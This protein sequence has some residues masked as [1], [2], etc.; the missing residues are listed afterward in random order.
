MKKN[1]LSIAILAFIFT[2]CLT[3]NNTS[4]GS[5]SD[6]KSATGLKVQGK[7][8][9]VVDWE[10]YSIGAEAVP[11]WLESA[12]LGN[13][14]AYITTFNKSDSDIYRYSTAT[15][16][17]L[18]SAQMRADMNYSRKIAKE[19]QQSINV[20]S[21]EQARAG[22]LSDTT[23]Q[24]IEEVT[25]TQSSVEIT[26]HQKATEFWQQV[27]VSDP[28]TGEKTSEY[29]VYQIYQIPAQTWA[30]TTAKYIKTVIGGVP[31]ELSPEQDFVKNLVSEMMY[32]ARFSTVMSQKEKEQQIEINKQ[33]ADIQASL[34]PAEQKAAADQALVQIMQSGQ[35]ERT[36]IITDAKVQQTQAMADATKIAYASGNPIYQSAATI[37][38]ADKDW[39]DAE[40]LAASILFN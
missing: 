33:M 10:G 40:A 2:G 23:R 16:Q 34:A 35:T 29:I 18:R 22:N 25:K 7:E 30:Q 1:L 13:Y 26:G 15:G 3:T 17:D 20:F 31:E 32:D 37:T 19:L 28:L 39:A 5:I 4:S 14:S 8:T 9:I 11:K 6:A 24:A 21:A 12:V 27:V 36:K 38:A